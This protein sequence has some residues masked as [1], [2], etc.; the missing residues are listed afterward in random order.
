MVKEAGYTF[1][2]GVST[3]PAVFGADP[4]DIRRIS[5]HGDN[6]L[7]GFVYQ[8]LGPYRRQPFVPRTWREAAGVSL[9]L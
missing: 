8:L 4:F 1:A 9:N 7:P 6:G 5:I 2:C 3:G